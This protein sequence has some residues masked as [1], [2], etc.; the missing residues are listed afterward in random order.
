MPNVPGTKVWLRNKELDAVCRTI[1]GTPP[2]GR[3]M[4]AYEFALQTVK[5]QRQALSNTIRVSKFV[6]WW[7][8][9]YGHLGEKVPV[10]RF[11]AMMREGQ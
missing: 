1:E 6:I 10:E 11:D 4:I 9:N 3:L 2:M 8:F 7:W 5:R